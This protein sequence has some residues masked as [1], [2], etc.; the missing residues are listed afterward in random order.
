MM[1]FSLLVLGSTQAFAGS[2]GGGNNNQDST[3]APR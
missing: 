1:L 3:A 2:G